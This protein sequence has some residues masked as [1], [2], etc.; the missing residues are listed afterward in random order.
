MGE[1]DEQASGR[2]WR[3]AR[4]ALSLSK[5]VVMAVLN[6]T[7]DSFHDGGTLWSGGALEEERLRAS[8]R[9]AVRAGAGLLDVGGES[10]R[11]GAEPVDTDLERR[12][13]VAAI[14][15]LEG[16]DVPISVDTRRAEVAHA[17]LE[18]G[19]VIVNDVSG[20]ADPDMVGVVLRHRAGVVVGHL[21]GQPKS[22]QE[23][24]AFERLLAEVVSELGREVERALAAGVSKPQIL[25]DPGVGFGKTAQQSAALVASSQTIEADVGVPVVIGASRKSFI[26]A[27]VPCDAAERLPGSLAAAVVAVQHG[28]AVVRV[29][30]VAETVQALAVAEAIERA[31]SEALA[32]REVRA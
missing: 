24:I 12:R 4:G 7:P 16:I 21:R 6:I 30:D 15:A 17:A 27:S 1:G 2:V 25:V 32:A 20:L 29:H 13:V 28:A 23:E 14:E 22:M 10:T 19:A 8:A 18:A 11:P 3:H 26:S 5:P 9:A 31:L